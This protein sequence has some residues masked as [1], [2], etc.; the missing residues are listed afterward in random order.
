MYFNLSYLIEKYLSIK[1]FILSIKYCMNNIDIHLICLLLYYMIT[2][3][4]YDILI[5]LCECPLEI[6]RLS[7]PYFRYGICYFIVNITLYISHISLTYFCILLFLFYPLVSATLCPCLR[8]WR[9]GGLQSLWLLLHLPHHLLL[10]FH[11]P[12]TMLLCSWCST[13][14]ET[15]S[16]S[17]PSVTSGKFRHVRALSQS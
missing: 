13:T 15:P 5:I 1:T 6:V 16:G 9:Q 2:Y 17:V 14:R 12:M 7:C 3:Y 4:I 10:L 8:D 11:L